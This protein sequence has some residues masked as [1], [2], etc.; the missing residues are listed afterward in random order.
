MTITYQV[1]PFLG[2]LKS[3]QPVSEVSKQLE[4]A[5]NAAA[6]NG[7]ELCQIAALSLT[8]QPGC[9]AGL[10]G[11]E[12]SYGSI[13]V[14]PFRS[15]F[16]EHVRTMPFPVV[17]AELTAASS[18]IEVEP[19]NVAVEKRPELL[20]MPIVEK[21]T[22]ST[23][24]EE[25]LEAPSRKPLIWAAGAGLVLVAGWY[26]VNFYKS[27]KIQPAPLP[28]AAPASAR[29]VIAAPTPKP[30]PV[31]TP[32]LEKSSGQIDA[33]A[34]VSGDT[35]TYETLDHAEPKFN[36][37][38]TRTITSVGAHG[39]EMNVVNAKSGYTRQLYYDLNA[40]LIA[41][42]GS[43]GE[44]FEYQPALQYFN[45]PLKSGDTWG[46][47]STETNKKT[48]K[49]RTHVVKGTI[50]GMER[51]TVPAGEFQVIKIEIVSEVRDDAQVTY[52]MDTSWYSPAARRTVKSELESRDSV[53]GKTGRRTVSL[54][55]YQLHLGSR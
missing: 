35:Y 24:V 48:G 1:L 4:Q 12:A 30:V 50:G 6:A 41:S 39:F 54:L 18:T 55:S 53:T 40:N 2:R 51:V 11:A 16:A 3:S 22:V 28:V 37:I 5:L 46:A 7:T 9:I 49:I 21:E 27:G 47:T 13:T 33:P 45:F 52:G 10:L 31:A 42:R 29:S 32:A 8:T 15:G 25:A 26:G 34:V 17:E 43:A 36:N 20:P 23:D 38:T 19:V 44:G 14:I